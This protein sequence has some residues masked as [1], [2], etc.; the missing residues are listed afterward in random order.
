VPKSLQRLLAANL[1]GHVYAENDAIPAPDFYLPIM[2][3]PLALKKFQFK[4][5]PPTPYFSWPASAPPLPDGPGNKIG[6]VWAGS[7]THERDFERSIPLAQFAPLF[8]KIPACFFA[9][10]TGYGLKR[11]EQWPILKLDKLIGDFA[12]TAALLQQLDYLVTVDT[13]VA[14]LAG[15]LGVKTYLLLPYAPDWRWGTKGNTTPWYQSFTLLRQPQPGDWES[16]I[17]QLIESLSA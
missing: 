7:G 10:F 9:P 14:H 17:G 12:D 1:P 3:L 13:A 15:A 5:A 11:I 6:L 16:V 8:E 2:S 4:Q